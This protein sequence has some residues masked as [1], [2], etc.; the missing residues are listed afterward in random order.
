MD[1]D[2]VL[3]EPRLPLHCAV[4]RDFHHQ[5]EGEGFPQPPSPPLG[6]EPVG[7]AEGTATAVPADGASAFAWSSLTVRK[8]KLD[9]G[10]PSQWILGKVRWR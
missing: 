4:L 9:A 10:P 7:W 5:R 3:K 8:L 1:L 6:P 2:V